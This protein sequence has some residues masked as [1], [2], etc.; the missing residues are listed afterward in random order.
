MKKIIDIND[1]INN[2]PEIEMTDDEEF[3]ML[4]HFTNEAYKWGYYISENEYL[5]DDDKFH[6]DMLI[7]EIDTLR[8][9]YSKF[10]RKY[11]K[12]KKKNKKAV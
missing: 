2:E 1:H 5:S 4:E 6:V 3:E 8:I 9:L 10:F 12:L 7:L 11:N